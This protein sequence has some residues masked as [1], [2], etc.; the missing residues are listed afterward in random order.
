MLHDI[1][2]RS[3]FPVICAHEGTFFSIGFRG[4]LIIGG[5]Q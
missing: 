3:F 5:I 4:T 2:K 1:K